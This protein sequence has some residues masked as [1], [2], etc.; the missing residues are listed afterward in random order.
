MQL[1][2]FS[3][4]SEKAYGACVYLRTTDTQDKHHCVLI[5]SKSRVALIKNQTLPRLELCAAILLAQLLKAT[6]QSLR[7]S[8]SKT[9]LWSD[10]TIVLNWINSPPHILPTF[11]ANR[12][13]EIQRI[14]DSSAW[15]HVRTH[16]NPADFV[17]R[18]QS[19]QEFLNNQLWMQGPEWLQKD[20]SCWPQLKFKINEKA[21]PNCCNSQVHLKI[22]QSN[23]HVWDRYNSFKK[24]QSIVAYCYRLISDARTSDAKARLYGKLSTAEL[25]SAR[26]TIIKSVQSISFAKE[27]TTLRNNNHVDKTS[28]LV[29]LNPF[30]DKGILRVGGRLI[31]S[32]IPESQKHP[33]VLP[34][35]HNVTRM[36][37]R[38]EHVKRYHAGVNATLY[39]VREI[40]WPLDGRNTVRHILK[41]CIPC[42]RSKPRDF[43]YIMSNLPEKRVTFTRPFLNVG[44]DYCGP[45]FIK[46]HRHRNRTNLKTYVSIFVCLATK[47]VHLE[48]ASDLTTEGFLASLKRFFARRGLASSM[49]SDN[50]KN[51][52]GASG[53]IKELFKQIKGFEN[54]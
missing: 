10:S 20:E 42:F 16:D 33:I 53:E 48:L 50:G 28:H 49:P 2:G 23:F 30:I 54:D 22:S 29:C 14:T 12:V 51:F 21:E 5:C 38:D 9:V 32:N 6:T 35:N 7:L 39:G 37:I 43:D 40:Y 52:V 13:A 3:D 17:S 34:K 1:H 4:A 25:N 26:I 47:A 19:P 31:R 41:Q 46:E 24:L 15:Q 18:G 27:L 11:V 8:F 36:I 44:V 45:F